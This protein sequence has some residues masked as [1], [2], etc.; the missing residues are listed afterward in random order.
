[1][2]LP[3]SLKKAI[4]KGAGVEI[5]NVIDGYEAFLLADIVRLR[6]GKTPVVFVMRDG[7]RVA[8]L[9]DALRFVAPDL[10]VLTLPAWDCLPYDRVGPSGDAA[11]RGL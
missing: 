1:M 3:P 7:N 8:A 10:P 9:E 4:E 5:G 11:G 6:G 2:S